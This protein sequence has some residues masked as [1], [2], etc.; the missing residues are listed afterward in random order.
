MEINLIVVI[1][2]VVVFYRVFNSR[3]L[4]FHCFFSLSLLKYFQRKVFI[5]CYLL[6]GQFPFHFLSFSF[7]FIV[8]HFLFLVFIHK[9]SI[10]ITGYL[11]LFLYVLFSSFFSR[12]NNFY[13]LFHFNYWSLA[14]EN[15]KR[16]RIIVSIFFS[17]NSI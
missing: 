16:F 17:C 13:L 1:V 14:K 7:S 9:F 3:D 2:V 15:E 8:Y 6:Y 11:F 12:K 5:V 4:N 10:V